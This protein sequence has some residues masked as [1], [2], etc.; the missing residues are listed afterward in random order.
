[1]RPLAFRSE[2]TYLRLNRHSLGKWRLAG[3]SRTAPALA[4]LVPLIGCV[5]END[6]RLKKVSELEASVAAMS[7]Q[8]NAAE[9][10]VVALE[11]DLAGL[12]L[13]AAPTKT[14]TF[15]PANDKG[16]Q[17]LDSTVGPFL[18]SFHGATPYLDGLR[19]AC[20]LGNPTSVR[21]DGVKL[22]VK[23]GPRLDLTDKSTKYADWLNSLHEKEVSLSENL[24]PGSWNR[25]SFVLS[26]AK[27]ESFGY[28]ELSVETDTISL[29]GG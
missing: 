16:Y 29:A 8:L 2:R 22:K 9:N 11:T 20:R 1:M 12:R 14:V 13:E 27:Q 24:L 25:V 15:D 21:F 4:L 10:R 28:L 7:V 26:P 19:I 6:A 18:V 23:W 5:A 17:R 3:L